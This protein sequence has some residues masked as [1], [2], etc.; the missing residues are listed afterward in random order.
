M[1]AYPF[2]YYE[3]DNTEIKDLKNISND[4]FKER[5]ITE[6]IFGY[7][8]KFEDEE[9]IE[10]YNNDWKLI[11]SLKL[12]KSFKIRFEKNIYWN[13]YWRRVGLYDKEV[14]NETTT[15]EYLF[16][17]S[18]Y[19]DWKNI[20]RQSLEHEFKVK[21]QKYIHWDDYYNYQFYVDSDYDILTNFF[22]NINFYESSWDNAE[23]TYILT[24]LN[25][26]Q[27]ID[28]TYISYIH[29]NPHLI[30]ITPTGVNYKCDFIN[31]PIR[32][33]D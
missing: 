1:E 30:K 19:N 22:S 10:F 29:M 2:E 11:S 7:K 20:S 17:K 25:I 5:G 8:Q 14:D 6:I 28:D 31:I 23:N 13:I 27:N 12:T 16:F 15:K 26:Q 4:T 3:C 33:Y 9:F 21:Y 24:A 32:K 18:F